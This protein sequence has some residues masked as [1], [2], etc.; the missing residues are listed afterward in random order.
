MTG[1]RPGRS[2]GR[3]EHIVQL[4]IPKAVLIQTG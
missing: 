3:G 1:G 4:D 2:D